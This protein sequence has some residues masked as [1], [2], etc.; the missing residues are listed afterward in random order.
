MG[1]DVSGVEVTIVPEN[2]ETVPDFAFRKLRLLKGEDSMLVIGGSSCAWSFVS[3]EASTVSELIAEELC[4]EEP[5]GPD[6]VV[7]D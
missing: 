5:V 1:D 3:G 4:I 7:D 2:L 6:G